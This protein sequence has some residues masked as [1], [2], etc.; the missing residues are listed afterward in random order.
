MVS[1]NRAIATAIAESLIENGAF[2]I[3]VELT[4]DTI[5]K[6]KGRYETDGYR[7]DD[8]F[9]GTGAWIVTR[10]S[11]TVE[12]CVVFTY[13]EHG[14]EIHNSITPNIALIEYYAE[15]ELTA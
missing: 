7:E 2:D 11:V 15:R 3:E 1:I 5:A 8:Y 13:N 14:E 12:A 10:A 4:A 9:N 6:A